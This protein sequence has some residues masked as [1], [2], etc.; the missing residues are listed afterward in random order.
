MLKAE[1][2]LWGCKVR[3]IGGANVF[4]KDVSADLTAAKQALQDVIDSEKYGFALQ[5]ALRMYLMSLKRII[6]K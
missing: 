3:P 2:L 4:S 1:I 6:R 5:Q